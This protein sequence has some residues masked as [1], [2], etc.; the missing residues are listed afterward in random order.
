MDRRLDI[1]LWA[2]LSRQYSWSG[3]AWNSNDTLVPD[4]DMEHD[5]SR[6]GADDGLVCGS[7][8]DDDMEP[9]M[10]A[11]VCSD[12]CDNHHRLLCHNTTL[13]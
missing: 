12:L 9:R 1:V 2:S 13:E 10:V 11:A 8:G 3:C 7:G 6:L 5:L 4:R